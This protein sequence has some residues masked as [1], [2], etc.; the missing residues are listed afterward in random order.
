V[1]LIGRYGERWARDLAAT[2][3]RRQRAWG[4]SDG[5]KRRAWLASLPRLCEALLKADDGAGRQAGRLLLQDSWEALREAIEGGRDLAS[6][7][8]RNET[9]AA[10]AR[11]LSGWLESAAVVDATEL[12]DEAIA[13]LTR[14][15]NEALVPSLVRML[16][17]AAKATEPSRRAAAGLDAIERH[18]TRWLQAQLAHPARRE[19]DWSI[20][21]PPGC[22]CELCKTLAAFLA[23]PAEEQLEWPINKERRQHVHR[24]IDAH[25]LPVRHRTRRSGSPYTLVLTKT[26]A[27]FELEAAERRAR[28]ADL[29]W[30]RGD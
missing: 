9:L 28:Q 1:E 19:G 22:S 24:R 2:W 14:Q 17:M 8:Q 6:P 21:L 29:D 27:L 7:S 26:N 30:L 11:P 13:F 16:R 12:R 20:T 5:Q 3:S 18:C 23:D 10:L 15:E 4:W 25:E